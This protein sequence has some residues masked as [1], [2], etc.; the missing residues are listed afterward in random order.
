MTVFYFIRHGETD[1]AMAGKKFY[2]GFGCHLL[3]LSEKGIEQM[4][5]AAADT[6]LA[7]AELLIT[8]P[9]GRAM[10]S[11]AILSKDLQ[12][13]LR[14]ETDLH[15]WLADG[16]SYEFLPDEEAEKSY[17]CLTENHGRHSA[18][19][20]CL[21]ESAVQMKK[22]VMSALDKYRGYRSVIVVCHGTLMQ[23][24][25]GI[26]HPQNGQIEEFIVD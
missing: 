20:V 18:G 26:D 11:A 3:T 23:Y 25:L 7:G 6:R 16:V 10:H 21:W 2:K 1:T 19:E 15:E 12:V 8:S 5:K 9:F 4:H 22:R 14:V 17:R 24:V 13:E